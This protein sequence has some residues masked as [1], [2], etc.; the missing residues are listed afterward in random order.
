MVHMKCK[1]I[2]MNSTI[3]Q[4]PHSQLDSPPILVLHGLAHSQSIWRR[5]ARH[6]MKQGS[7]WLIVADARNHGESPHCANHKPADMAADVEALIEEKK[8]KRIVALGHDMGGRA[9][10]TLALTRPYLVERVIVV[11]ITPGPLPPEVVNASRMFE[12]MVKVLPTIPKNLS[13]VQGRKF[14]LPQIRK[15]IKNEAQL[16]MVIKNLSIADNGTFFWA[17]NAQ[18]IYNDWED[19][20]VNYKQ[21]IKGLQPYQGDTLLIAGQKTNFVTPQNVEIMKKY[22]PKLHVEYLNANHKVH[23]DQPQQFVQLV[24]DFTMGT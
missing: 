6:I 1:A 15:F 17:V 12:F 9:M 19:L 8:L 21:T 5:P 7:R 11:D 16:M 13:L 22:F 23:V 24:V 4:M 20:M 2:K 3:Y 18:A 10:M 14:I